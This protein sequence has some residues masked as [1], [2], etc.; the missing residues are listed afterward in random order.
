M[1]TTIRE[2]KR[3]PIDITFN[4]IVPSQNDGLYTEWKK[5]LDDILPAHWKDS[6]HFIR[7]RLDD[8]PPETRIDAIVSPAN[9]YGRMGKLLNSSSVVIAAKSKC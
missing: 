1:A 8:L 6:F 3:T 7:A 9:S 4:L 5:A 2:S